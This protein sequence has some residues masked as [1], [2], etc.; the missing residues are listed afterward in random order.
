MK[1]SGFWVLFFV[2]GTA[3]IFLNYSRNRTRHSIPGMVFTHHSDGMKM[4]VTS[5]KLKE[6]GYNPSIDKKRDVGTINLQDYS[7]A[8]P[9]PSKASVRSAPVHHYTPSDP[10]IPRPLPPGH[11]MNGGST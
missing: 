1:I 5:R 3:G 6:N 4:M 2:L 7:P 10:Y 9:A 8:D 11:P